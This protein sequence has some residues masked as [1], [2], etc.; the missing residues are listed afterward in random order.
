MPLKILVEAATKTETNENQEMGAHTEAEVVET[1][2]MAVQTEAE[3][4][5]MNEVEVQTE[6]EESMDHILDGETQ[7]A[8]SQMEAAEL[9]E[10]EEVT[11]LKTRAS[12]WKHHTNQ[13]KKCMI[14]LTTHKK[15][16][17]ELREQ[18]T[19]DIFFQNIRWEEMQ[20]KLKYLKKYE[21]MEKN[22]E[23]MLTLTWELL[24]CR[25]PSPSYPVFFF[26]NM[27]LLKIKVLKE[28]RPW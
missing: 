7:D 11:C 20:E 24:S 17:H 3:T 5:E 16:I 23:Q 25:S 13:F 21:A 6:E 15:V 2:E 9:Q 28:G 1:H 10:T 4:V 18:W 26:Q 27:T 19:E 22:K 8:S 12:R 14:S